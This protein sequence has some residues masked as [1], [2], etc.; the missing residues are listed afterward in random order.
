M[1]A[2]G[3]IRP[4]ASMNT[5]SHMV[6]DGVIVSKLVDRFGLERLCTLATE[7]DPGF[8]REIFI[9]MLGQFSK[10]LRADFDLTDSEY[11]QLKQEVEDWRLHLR[12]L[13]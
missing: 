2:T 8:D 3:G 6:G 4:V 7:R 1:I 12:G 13:R 5:G 9:Q 10:W 11:A